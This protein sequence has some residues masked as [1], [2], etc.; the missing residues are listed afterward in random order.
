MIQIILVGI[1]AGLAAALLFV[2][3]VGGTS[4]ALPLF[5]IT[6]VPIA[7]AGLGW[8]PIAGVI[9]VVAGSTVVFSVISPLAA[10][11]FLLLFAAPTAWLAYL[12]GLWRQGADGQ[13][14]FPL[15]RLL[16]HAAIAVAVGLAIV[17]F[18]IGYNPEQMAA[19][20]TDAL[21]EWLAARPNLESV[22]TR[23]EIEPFVRLNVSVL[24]Y[25]LAALVLVVLVV[26]LWL[27]GWITRTSGRLARPR[28]RLWTASLPAVAATTFVVA[29]IASLIPFPLGEVAALASGAFG[30]AFLLLGL[31]VLHSLTIGINGRTA[32]LT[33]NY[34]ALVFLGFTVV[35]IVALGLAET[36]LH[37]R[38]R[39]FGKAPPP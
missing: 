10:G 4:L 37:L 24:P 36:F 7:I 39:R 31:A 29:S 21:S 20:M 1:G 18:L 11:L 13:E 34:V 19:E 32:L 26:N 38:A 27:A 35:L 17:G 28:E 25:T 5:T 8:T 3:P 23:T 30:G 22:P 14:W 6:G 15:G 33:L 12:A 16:V 9:S 2:S